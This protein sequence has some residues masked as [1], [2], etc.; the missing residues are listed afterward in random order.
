MRA[1]NLFVATLF[2]LLGPA[3]LA[4]GEPSGDMPTSAELRAY[5]PTPRSRAEVIADLEIY[6]RSGLAAL[7]SSD[8]PDAF[9]SAYAAAQARYQAMRAAPAFRQR[10]ARIAHE[11]GEVE[12]TANSG[13]GTVAQ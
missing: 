13:G 8:S 5:S 3:A 9:S 4:Q 7:D 10:V 12:A 2:A 1:N 11:R 6:R